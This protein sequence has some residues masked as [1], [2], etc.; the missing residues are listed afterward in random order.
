MS[1]DLQ[2]LEQE[3]LN[4]PRNKGVYP[5]VLTAF[6]LARF[7]AS[8]HLPYIKG[9]G[10]DER[11]PFQPSGNPAGYDCSG[12]ASD[13]WNRL[14]PIGRPQTT[15]QLVNVGQRGEGAHATLWVAQYPGVLEH[16]AFEFKIPSVPELRWF[17]AS[18]PGA[19]PEVGFFTPASNNWVVEEPFVYTPRC[20][21]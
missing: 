10:H 20:R 12:A 19:T 13:V 5:P 16:C 6:A 2:A 21:K 8:Q 3:L 11:H 18:H 1:V 9:G 14:E 4:D 15:A 7:R 17:A